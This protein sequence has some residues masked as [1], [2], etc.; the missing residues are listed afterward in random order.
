MKLLPF[1]NWAFL[2]SSVSCILP[3]L[4][5]A[6][7][8]SINC[9]VWAAGE[10]FFVSAQSLV[11][12]VTYFVH[13]EAVLLLKKSG[14]VIQ[15]YFLVCKKKKKKCNSAMQGLVVYRKIVLFPT[16]QLL[17]LRHQERKHWCDVH[18]SLRKCKQDVAII[19]HPGFETRKYCAW[20][21]SNSVLANHV[22][23]RLAIMLWECVFFVCVCFF[24][25]NV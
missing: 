3:G 18:I 16:S 9:H 4:I 21:K 25:L 7:G 19:V 20:M 5:C 1:C 22:S 10:T 12:S 6:D 23:F 2:S 24:L 15:L 17:V 13:R 14:A 8:N 11:G